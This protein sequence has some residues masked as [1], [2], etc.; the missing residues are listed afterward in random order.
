[1][2]A[3]WSEEYKRKLTTADEAVKVV[4][5]GDWV[6]VGF[7]A[8]MPP[9]LMNA[10]AKRYNELRDVNLRDCM[11]LLP[12]DDYISENGQSA[13]NINTWF[14]S[15]KMR[16]TINEGPGTFN[17]AYFG[18]YCPLYYRYLDTDV[19]MVSVSP[20][21]AHG[22][23]SFGAA[24][25]YHR[26][27]ADTAK[28][29]V[30]EVNENQPY[31][32]GDSFIHISQVD[33]IIENHCSLPTIKAPALTAED[34]IIGNIVSEYIE[35]GSTVQLG[36][37]AMPNA[38]G[39]ALKGKKN[40]GVHSEMFC[41]SMI[42]LIET[43]VITGKEKSLHKERLI[44]TFALGSDKLYK[45]MSM[46]PMIE[47]YPVSYTNNPENI[48]KNRKMVA[49]NATVEVDLGGQCASEAIGT[50]QLSGVGGQ[51]D[52]CR[53]AYKSEGGKSFICLHSTAKNGTISKIVSSLT[54]GTCVTTTRAEVHHIVTEYGVA[55]LKGKTMKQRAQELIAIAHP[56][57]RDELKEQA[58]KMKLI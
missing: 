21:D 14:V 37:G 40:L 33:S 35:D 28:K 15:A 4:K 17:P 38:V 54:P 16:K 5:S 19:T 7:A 13:F 2:T 49:I 46:N 55:M 8:G 27:A 25:T 23:F 31:V 41:D 24:V 42:D 43:G 47:F 10:L 11:W 6:D 53:G 39:Y 1:M 18:D 58:R 22:Y 57:F 44:A 52:F 56:D 20:M 51:M 50:R 12:L 3:R 32:F 36:I 48:A 34:E 9:A 45:F 29:V 26:A 30:L